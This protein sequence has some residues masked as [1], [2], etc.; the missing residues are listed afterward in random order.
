MQLLLGVF[1][2]GPVGL[3]VN[4]VEEMFPVVLETALGAI[5][6]LDVFTLV[7]QMIFV[8]L[9]SLK[10]VRHSFVL[11]EN[12]GFFIITK[13]RTLDDLGNLRELTGEE[14]I[15]NLG[16]LQ[17]FALVVLLVDKFVEFVLLPVDKFQNLS[18]VLFKLL[19]WIKWRHG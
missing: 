19:L 15:S 12:L 11:E 6:N 8:L 5:R 14:L 10:E 18:E 13:F 17:D 1:W 2:D 4:L 16:K 3:F 9:E 7:L